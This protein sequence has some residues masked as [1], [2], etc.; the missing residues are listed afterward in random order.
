[1]SKKPQDKG[2][3][4]LAWERLFA[5]YEILKRIEGNG[6][7]QISAAQIKEFREPRLMAK[8]DHT[9]NLPKIFAEND[10]A[11]LPITR[12]DYV[13]SHFDA[14][15]RFEPD[16]AEITRASLPTYVQSLDCN[17]V[18]S[19]T[20]ALNCAVAAGIVT[21]FL[22]DEA[23]LST[24]SG[25]MGSGN[26]TFTISNTSQKTANRIEVHNSQ[27]E[28]DAAFEGISS[29]SLFEAKRDLSEDF[30]VRQLYY[31]FRVW[32]SRV[33]KPVRPIFLVYSNG[34]YRLYEYCF[35][36]PTNYSSLMLLKQKNYSIEDTELTI[37]DIQSV[38]YTTAT[39]PAEPAIAFPQADSFER[40][41]NL[42]ELLSEQEMSRGKVTEEYA[43]NVRQTNYYTDAGR[44]LGLLGKTVKEG[45]PHYKLTDKGKQILQMHFKQRQ[46]AFCKLILS[47]QVFHLTLEQ[48]FK[49]GVMPSKNQIVLIMKQSN[50]Y[51][52]HSDVTFERRSST[53]RGWVN[54]I[55]ELANE[56]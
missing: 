6:K 10:L 32:K 56:E 47:H 31:P 17:N 33:T 9:V 18:L 55:V 27:I 35:E 45:S 24:V 29:L 46:L 36:E 48:Y 34:I 4:E 21:E 53:I 19:E 1:M 50:L 42:C 41:I 28:I 13:I 49:S 3:T 22:E 20:V 37:A 26:F 15:H 8:F 11:I 7:F 52:V 25:R 40:V 39:D 54:W 38:L 2:L 14:Y 30:L 12:G 5:K 51:N 16:V 44:Y 43:F 23:I